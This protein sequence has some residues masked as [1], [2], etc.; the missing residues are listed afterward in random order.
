M[1]TT[2][3][4]HRHRYEIE[5]RYGPGIHILGDPFTNLL[6]ARISSPEFQPPLLL[7]L[8]SSFFETLLFHAAAVDFPS[9]PQA[10]PTRMRD[11]VPEGIW[12]GLAA[13]PSTRVVI[14]NVMRAGLMPSLACFRLLSSILDAEHVRLD[15]L[16]L[17]RKADA[18]GHVVGVDAMGS[19]IGG[20]IDGAVLIIPDPMG[21]TGHTILK[22]LELYRL[23]GLGRPSCVLALHLIITPEYIRSVKAGA[24]EVSVWAGRLD[25]GLSPSDVLD[26][27]P[28]THPDR[29]RGLTD[30]DYIVP[31]AGGM[32]EVLNNSFC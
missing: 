10:I 14:A 21:A 7:D 6:L 9:R 32:G 13:D 25:R 31:G 17:A 23:R 28:G 12:R 24:P 8:V 30:H 3:A 11:Q 29:E 15:H 2:E 5:H 16:Y 18:R 19:K 1:G 4:G 27:V 22:T 26:T 20:S